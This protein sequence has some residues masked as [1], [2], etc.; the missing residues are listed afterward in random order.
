MIKNWKNNLTE[1]QCLWIL[2]RVKCFICC[3][4]KWYELHQSIRNIMHNALE[5]G[6][7]SLFI[8]H[9]FRLI[10]V[11]GAILFVNSFN[12]TMFKS[13]NIIKHH[14]DYALA[15]DSAYTLDKYLNSS[16]WRETFSAWNW[17]IA[18]AS[19]VHTYTS[20]SNVNGGLSGYNNN[21]Y[22]NNLWYNQF[23]ISGLNFI[24]FRLHIC[25]SNKTPFSIAIRPIERFFCWL[26]DISI[27]CIYS[28]DSRWQTKS[29]YK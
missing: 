1:C 25:N 20:K 29:K 3:S 26:A 10:R 6:D 7:D 2:C 27:S 21:I 22:H 24:P 15:G 17:R 16:S 14:I 18:S 19:F 11:G 4:I 5:N 8:W 28:I 9:S 12:G 23:F 13:N